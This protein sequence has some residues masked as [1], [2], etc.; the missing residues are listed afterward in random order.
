M[1]LKPIPGYQGT[2]RCVY[3]ENI[4]GLSYAYSRKKADEIL[5]KINI[6]KAQTLLK[7]SKY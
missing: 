2:N 3:P 6:E 7:S 5:T 4:Y 1:N